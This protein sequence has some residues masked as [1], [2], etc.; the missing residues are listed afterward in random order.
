MDAI[1][2]GGWGS[3][4]RHFQVRSTSQIKQ[5]PSVVNTPPNSPQP[6]PKKVEQKSSPFSIS[7]FFSSIWKAICSFSLFAW[8]SNPSVNENIAN[9]PQPSTKNTSIN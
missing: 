5:T 8:R 4:Y 3:G 2:R 9:K 7:E 6:I 1:P